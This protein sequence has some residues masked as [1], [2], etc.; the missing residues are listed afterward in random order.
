MSRDRV[1]VGEGEGARGPGG[2]RGGRGHDASPLHSPSLQSD[3]KG[4]HLHFAA[5]SYR[6]WRVSQWRLM[7][8]VWGEEGGEEQKIILTRVW[9]RNAPQTEAGIPAMSKIL[10]SRHKNTTHCSVLTRNLEKFYTL[11][12][13]TIFIFNFSFFFSF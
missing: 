9:G 1:G 2:C 5:A 13:Y 10:T 12:L 7:T 6:C 4:T 11:Q 8:E 3:I